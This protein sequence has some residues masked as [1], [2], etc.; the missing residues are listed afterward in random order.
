M[1]AFF[2]ALGAISFAA[3]AMAWA[4][5]SMTRRFVCPL[6]ADSLLNGAVL[7]G[8]ISVL[9]ASDTFDLVTSPNRTSINIIFTT[10]AVVVQVQI[11]FVHR[12][13]HRMVGVAEPGGGA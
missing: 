4:Y 3:L 6:M 10:V 5:V 2:V 13:Y 7:C 12:A 9:L 1:T 8:A 11:F